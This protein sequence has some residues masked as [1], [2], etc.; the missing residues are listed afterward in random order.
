MS[1]CASLSLSAFLSPCCRAPRR[2]ARQPL[3]QRGARSPATVCRTRGRRAQHVVVVKVVVSS[4]CRK[5]KG[6]GNMKG[7]CVVCWCCVHNQKH[8]NHSFNRCTAA[9]VPFQCKTEACPATHPF[10]PATHQTPARDQKQK[11]YGSWSRIMGMAPYGYVYR[12]EWI[13]QAEL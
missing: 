13:K 1:A 12:H 4:C 3:H 2:H 9:Q 11:W 7:T 8:R 6:R 10:V 5:S